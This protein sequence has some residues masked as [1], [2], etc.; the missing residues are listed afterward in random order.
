MSA[1]NYI[2]YYI[3]TVEFCLISRN[4]DI[5]P[6][7]QDPAN[8]NVEVS[9]NTVGSTANYSCIDDYMLVGPQERIC[10]ADVGWSGQDPACCEF[11][12]ILTL[13]WNELNV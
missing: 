11:I 5:C 12:V 8:G 9:N 4:T 6:V 1:Y 13:F 10:T 7:L 3:Y 2:Y